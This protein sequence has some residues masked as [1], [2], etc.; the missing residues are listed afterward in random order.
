MLLRKISFSFFPFLKS[1]LKKPIFSNQ[2]IVL[3]NPDTILN[4]ITVYCVRVLSL[5]LRGF[6]DQNKNF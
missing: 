4:G 2:K 6:Y 1:Y 3:E 5:L